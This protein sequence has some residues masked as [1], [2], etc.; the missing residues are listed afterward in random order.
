MFQG[1]V[2]CAYQ[3]SAVVE[4]PCKYQAR[5]DVLLD[6]SHT[7]S[8]VSIIMRSGVSNDIHQFH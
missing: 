5:I 1:D 8:P 2:S 7:L 3:P 4:D 6:E